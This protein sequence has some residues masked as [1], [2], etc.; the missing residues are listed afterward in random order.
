[1]PLRYFTVKGSGN[2]P[3]EML[4]RSEAFPAST[5]EGEKIRR[6]CPTVTDTAIEITLATEKGMIQDRAWAQAKW[7][8]QKVW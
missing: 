7:P 5:S 4:S 8:I 6:A 3:F 2:F 1:M